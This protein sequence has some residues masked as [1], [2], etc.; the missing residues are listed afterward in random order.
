[1]P[2][3]VWDREPSE[4]FAEPYEYGGQE[5]FAREAN[6][7]LAELKV[8]YA[9]LD[10]TF[11]RDEKSV[12]KAVWMLQ[13]DALGAL[14]D[15]L[16]LTKDKRHRLV[17]RLFRD[18]I[19]TMDASFYFFQCGEKASANLAKWYDNEVIPHRVFREFIK[20]H[21]GNQQFEVLR[22]T[23]SDF[24][25]YTH[26]TYKAL[27]MSYILASEDK[28]AYDGF[29]RLDPDYVLPHVV[30]FSYAVIA[31]LTKRFVDFSTAT[32]QLS[33]NQANAL[34]EKCLESE[35]VP[36]RFGTGLGQLM[37]GPLIELQIR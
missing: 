28:L 8:H 30:S 33:K 3:F 4:A 24:S 1:M 34:W 31:M 36:R 35:T 12:P 13:V 19:E 22:S 14:T 32:E 2:S 11:A 29:R 26:R 6:A 9:R 5:Q 21:H 23:Y 7:V 20:S 15:A 27:L 37:R 25:K 17:S 18:F 16:A 10:R